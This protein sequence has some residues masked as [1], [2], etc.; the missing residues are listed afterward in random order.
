MV[1]LY[2]LL[3]TRFYNGVRKKIESVTSMSQD[4][5][6]NTMDYNRLAEL[7]FPDVTETPEEVEAGYTERDL[8]EGAKVSRRGT[9]QTG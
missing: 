9:R 8:Q 2:L 4:W 7:L 6:G 1:C 3:N 5:R